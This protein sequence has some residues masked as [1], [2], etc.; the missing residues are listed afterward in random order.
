MFVKLDYKHENRKKKKK[1][2]KKKRETFL[3]K[4]Q[5]N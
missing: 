1:K 4:L 2:K 5:K 3:K